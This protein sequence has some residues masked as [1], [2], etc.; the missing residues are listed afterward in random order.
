MDKYLGAKDLDGMLEALTDAVRYHHE[1]RNVANLLTEKQKLEVALKAKQD[2]LDRY[3]K[4]SSAIPRSGSLT[5]PRPAPQEGSLKAPPSLEDAFQRIA[6][7]K[8][9]DS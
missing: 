1:R 2:E 3:K 9:L 5:S 7:G 8:S 6:E 4:S